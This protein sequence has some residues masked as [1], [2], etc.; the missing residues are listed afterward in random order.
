MNNVII[1]TGQLIQQYVID[2]I[3]TAVNKILELKNGAGNY[4]GEIAQGASDLWGTFF[5]DDDEATKPLPG[6]KNLPNQ[7]NNTNN[8]DVKVTAN[9]N[10]PKD[11]GAAVTD[12]TYKGVLQAGLTG[13]TSK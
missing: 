9:I 13:Q 3:M 7:T 6:G 8:Y 5:G 11:S 12:A 1:A 4:L 10:N 2:P